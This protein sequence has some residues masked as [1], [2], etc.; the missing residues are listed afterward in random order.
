MNIL[1]GLNP[2]SPSYHGLKGGDNANSMTTQIEGERI[3]SGNNHEVHY[4]I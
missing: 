4:K 1:F 3:D 2:T